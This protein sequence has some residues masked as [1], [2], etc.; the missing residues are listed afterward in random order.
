MVMEN[1]N[2]FSKYGKDF[3]E[4]G[5]WLNSGIK[6][7]N[8][9][10]NGRKFG[11]EIGQIFRFDNI[12]QF[13]SNSGLNGNNSDLLISSFFDYKNFFSLKNISLLIFCFSS[14]FIC[15]HYIYPGIH[16]HPIHSSK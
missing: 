9:S 13:S 12:N 10:I 1:P 3:Q 7:E 11:S 4:K 16:S 14:V 6:Y 8:R 5:L 15:G 2:Y